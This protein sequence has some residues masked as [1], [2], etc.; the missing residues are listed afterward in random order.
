MTRRPLPSVPLAT[1]RLQEET[2][3]PLAFGIHGEV[4][5]GGTVRLGDELTVGQRIG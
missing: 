4:L 3:E 2:T 1:Y 5:S